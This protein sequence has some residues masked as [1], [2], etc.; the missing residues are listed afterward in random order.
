MRRQT[1]TGI[2]VGSVGIKGDGEREAGTY[3][4]ALLH[5]LPF[6]KY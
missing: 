2:R 3:Q 1:G 4:E 6:F 5:F